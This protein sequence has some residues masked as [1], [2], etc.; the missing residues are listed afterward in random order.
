MGPRVG[1][2][3][4]VLGRTPSPTQGGSGEG[5]TQPPTRSGD[6]GVCARKSAPGPPDRPGRPA[7]AR[8]QEAFTHNGIWVKRLLQELSSQDIPKKPLERWEGVAGPLDR[9]NKRV[10]LIFKAK[11][12]REKEMSLI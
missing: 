3:S 2:G 6:L 8:P 12:Q 4:G 11:L 7:A 1:L 5:A 9:E 10:A